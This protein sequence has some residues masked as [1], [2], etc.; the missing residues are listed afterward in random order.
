MEQAIINI[1]FL[2]LHIYKDW[3]YGYHAIKTGQTEVK[4]EVW[5]FTVCFMYSIVV[6]CTCTKWNV[7]LIF[8]KS[9]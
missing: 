3:I 8:K 4:A 9:D 7:L 5:F 2:T 1:P 6:P